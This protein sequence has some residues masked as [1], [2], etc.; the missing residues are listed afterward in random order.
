[1][2]SGTSGWFVWSLNGS[3]DTWMVSGTPSCH[4][5]LVVRDSTISP[6]SNLL[7]GARIAGE[8]KG[9]ILGMAGGSLRGA[10]GSNK[11]HGEGSLGG[12]GGNHWDQW[13]FQEESLE[14]SGGI[15]GGLR[16]D[17]QRGA[18]GTLGQKRDDRGDIWRDHWKFQGGSLEVSGGITRVSAGSQCG[19][20]AQPHPAALPGRPQAR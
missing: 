2:S 13:G 1:M 12:L 16:D 11:G 18:G 4:P 9:R 19:C 10:G 20:R 8:I 15:T 17:H 3:W 5:A 14:I 7:C 6:F